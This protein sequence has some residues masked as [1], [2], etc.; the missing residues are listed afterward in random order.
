MGLSADSRKGVSPGL[1]VLLLVV[2]TVVAGLLLYLWL[3]EYAGRAGGVER[4][5]QVCAVKVE[6]VR[7][8]E[9]VLVVYVR[10]VGDEA[11]VVD[12]VVVEGGGASYVLGVE[13]GG[14]EVRPGEVVEVRA[15][16]PSGLEPG[17][18]SVRVTTSAGVS[19]AG[20][21]YLGGRVGWLQGWSYR[22]AVTVVERSGTTLVG[23]QVRVVL[24]PEVFDYS[25]AR[26]DGGDLRFTDSDGV[27]LLPYWIERW[28]PGGVSVIWV[29]V[30]EVPAG[31]VKRIYMYYGNPNAEGQS[32]GRSVFELFDDFEDL[33]G[34]GVAEYGTWGPTRVRVVEGDEFHDGWGLEVYGWYDDLGGFVNVYTLE[35]WSVGEVGY[36]VEARV[37]PRL[38][39][40]LEIYVA[41][42]SLYAADNPVDS[43][44]KGF[45]L[46][47]SAAHILADHAFKV[48]G[49]YAYWHW[50]FNG[51]ESGDW[52]GGSLEFSLGS[53][54]VLSVACYGGRTVYRVWLD[55]DPLEPAVEKVLDEAYAAFRVVLGNNM[56][57]WQ[58]G[59]GSWTAKAWF[60]W[61]RVRKYV[62]PEPQVTLGPEEEAP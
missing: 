49:P 15:S 8:E 4:G 62:E 36:A 7:V 39:S 5:V 47:A 1:V 23:Y 59:G 13:G 28:D 52:D 25:K 26:S 46:Y 18:Y 42:L 9:S 3:A 50:R 48:T 54:Y 12:G 53:W 16:L 38:F 55:Q 56:P 6:G 33:Q 57:G 19:A 29:R 20:L 51:V 27:A 41:R 10:N 61:V 40:A 24:T 34:W 31:G 17:R 30:P 11:V 45:P 32:S 37:S 21:V 35:T 22:R 44:P 58:S 43:W 60:D 2:I 14:V